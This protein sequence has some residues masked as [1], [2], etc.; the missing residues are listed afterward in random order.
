MYTENIIAQHYGVIL[1][2]CNSKYVRKKCLRGRLNFYIWNNIKMFNIS[3]EN[4]I[5]LSRI[6]KIFLIMFN[7]C[8]KL[9]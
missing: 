1:T 4:D 3:V 7:N 5:Y 6:N 2:E 9:H 8:I